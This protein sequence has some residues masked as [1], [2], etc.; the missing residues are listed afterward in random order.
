MKTALT[1]RQILRSSVGMTGILAGL[2]AASKG[3]AGDDACEITPEQTEGPFY[4]VKPQSDTDID[5]TIVRGKNERA[6]GQVIFVEGRVTDD[7][8]QPVAKALVEIWQ[9]CATG[10]YNHPGDTSPNVLDP[11]FQYWGRALT[12]A[13]G[14]YSFKTILPGQY[15]ATPTWIRPPHIHYKV[16]AMGFHELTTQMYF[17]GH[18][19]N[20]KDLILRDVPKAERARVIVEFNESPELEKN[21]QSGTFDLTLVRVK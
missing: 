21:S 8:C 10:K 13:N 2:M 6:K 19:L 18:P 17:A 15:H 5:L 20:E 9:A 14:K 4:P 7:N 1:R 16:H 3:L 11:N 12:D